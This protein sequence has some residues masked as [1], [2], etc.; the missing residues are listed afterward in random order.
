M[1]QAV[2]GGFVHS[3]KICQQAKLN[4]VGGNG[5][6]HLKQTLVQLEPLVCRAMAAYAVGR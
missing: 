5:N 2:F 1:Q 6:T 3:V 4:L